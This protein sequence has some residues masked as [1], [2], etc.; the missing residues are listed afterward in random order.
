MT[1]LGRIII[2]H[3]KLTII[4]DR[5]LRI[6]S[7]NI[8][9]RSLGF[10]TECDLSFEADGRSGTG[11]RR[12]IQRLRTSLLAHWLG[13]D[14]TTVDEAINKAGC[15][16]LG[17]EA[18]RLAGYVRLRPIDVRPL[19]PLAEL[20]AAYHL[21]DPFSPKDSYRPWKRR[22]LVSDASRRSMAPAPGGP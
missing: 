12:E 6:G 8:N 22:A 21:G 11:N 1:A 13:C 9:N 17:L 4:D 20:V 7:A 16:V 10:D 5:L 14:D 18:L 2:V 19:N 3:A 15:V